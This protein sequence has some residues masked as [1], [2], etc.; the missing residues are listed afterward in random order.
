MA[1]AND[2]AH[3]SSSVP[4]LGSG[5]MINEPPDVPLEPVELVIVTMVG[6]RIDVGREYPRR[7]PGCSVGTG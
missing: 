5:P 4:A 1:G 2:R 7:R 3:G 6:R